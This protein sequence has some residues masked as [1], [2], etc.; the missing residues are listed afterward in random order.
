MR[1][2]GWI[3]AVSGLVGAAF[4]WVTD[5]R[6]GWIRLAGAAD[7]LIDASNTA[8]AGTA[9]GIAGSTVILLVGLWL[10]TRRSA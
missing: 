6:L 3:L 5:P 2:S 8:L 1:R 10:V 9:V 7:N 4:F